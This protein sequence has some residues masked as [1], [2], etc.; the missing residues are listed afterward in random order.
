MS[1]IATIQSYLVQQNEILLT[2][3]VGMRSGGLAMPNSDYDLVTITHDVLMPDRRTTI[4]RDLKALIGAELVVLVP[5][6][7]I[8]VRRPYAIVVHGLQLFERDLADRVAFE[9]Q[10]LNCVSEF[11]RT[12]CVLPP[13]STDLSARDPA[14][15]WAWKDKTKSICIKM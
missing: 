6:S 8:S 4:E 1:V 14:S 13:D 7:H 9:A 11:R 12:V 15:Q 10:V 2:Y 3:I 5:L